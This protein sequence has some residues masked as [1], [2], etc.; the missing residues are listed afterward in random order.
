V[1]TVKE[2]FALYQCSYISNCIKDRIDETWYAIGKI[3][4]ELK[5]LTLIMPSIMC[6]PH[7]SAECERVFSTVQ[8]NVTSQR[9]SL[10]MDTLE[11]LLGMKSHPGH[12]LNEKRQLSSDTLD[13]LKRAYYKSLLKTDLEET[14]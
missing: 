8:K 7:S 11:A 1:N 4:L 5:D 6:I 12:F 2:Q 14:K 9:A 3:Y 10:K 13:A